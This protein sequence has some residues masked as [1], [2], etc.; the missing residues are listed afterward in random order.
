MYLKKQ[1]HEFRQHLPTKPLAGEYLYVCMCMYRCVN[2]GFSGEIDECSS[3]LWKSHKNSRG[4]KAWFI[5]GNLIEKA[6]QKHFLKV[7]FWQK[8]ITH[9]IIRKIYYY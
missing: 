3:F 2:G 4:F 9:Y 5:D 6:I 8:I 7:N 1:E